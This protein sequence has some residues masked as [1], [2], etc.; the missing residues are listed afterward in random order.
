MRK[1]IL[2]GLLALLSATKLS[3]QKPNEITHFNLIFAPDLSNRLNPK[4]YPK[5]VNDADIVQGA[6]G[7]IWPDIL[8]IGRDEGQLDRY[9]VDFINKGLIGLY[10]IN[11]DI[12]VIDFQLFKR[13]SDRIN[14]ILA[15]NSVPRTLKQDV[16]VFMAEYQ[17]F[18]NKAAISNNGA[19]IWT[20]FQ[21]GIDDRIVLPALSTGGRLKHKF[22]NV[23]VLMTDGYIEAGIYGKGYDLSAAKVKDFR[24]AFLKSNIDDMNVF[25]S[26]NPKFKIKP[27]KN[28]FLKDLEVIVLEMYDRSLSRA[29]AATRHPTDMEIMKLIWTD[30]MRSSGVKRFELK[31]TASNKSE[32]VKY[33]IDFLKKP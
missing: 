5:A 18:N 29:G 10:K 14:Y 2:I 26:R 31:S 30:W 27:A 32:A 20:Y 24:N 25:L 8:R 6:M 12:L 16:S 3:A 7:K 4:L 19:D 28:P 13:Q 9:S 15:R 33:I 1:Y 22:R 23:M 21:S 11:T 17:K